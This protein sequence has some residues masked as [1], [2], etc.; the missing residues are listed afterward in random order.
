M[1]WNKQLFFKINGLVGRYK[2]LDIFGWV[3]G[4]II[5]FVMLILYLAPFIYYYGTQVPA[6]IIIYLQAGQLTLAWLIGI[7]LSLFIGWMVREPRPYVKHGQQVKKLFSSVFSWKSFPSDHTM[8]AFLL[9]FLAMIFPWYIGLI[10]FLL[11]VWVAWSRIYAGA[12]YPLDILGGILVAYIALLLTWFI[13]ITLSF[14]NI[15]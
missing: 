10:F 3:G 4:K 6:R 2:W 13:T 14:S 5:V 7:V 12:H 1:S 11:A 8:S 15:L 9:F